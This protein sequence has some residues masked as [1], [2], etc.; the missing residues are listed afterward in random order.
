MLKP[1]RATGPSYDVGPVAL[2]CFAVRQGRSL[3]SMRTAMSCLVVTD[4]GLKRETLKVSALHDRDAIR[5][6]DLSVQSDP[7]LP[8]LDVVTAHGA[9][10][11]AVERSDA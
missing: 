5:L 2:F 7:A 3:R 4:R 9:L 1:R 10:L 8:R 11:T 6:G